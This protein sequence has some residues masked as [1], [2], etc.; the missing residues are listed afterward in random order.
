M[1]EAGDEA[2]GRRCEQQGEPLEL[3]GRA[4]AAERDHL[5]P[6]GLRLGFGIER[7]AGADPG[8]LDRPGRDRIHGDA[9]GRELERR[10]AD[11]VDDRRL[12][13]DVAVADQ[14]LGLDPGDRRRRDDPPR[15]LALHDPRRAPDRVQD[16]AQVH[17]QHAPEDVRLDRVDRLAARD[18]E[19]GRSA[20]ARVGEHDVEPAFGLDDRVDG[21]LHRV[22][23]GHV[24]DLG[25]HVQPAAGQRRRGRSQQL[26]VHVGQRH[27][28][29]AVGK[30]LRERETEAAGRAGHERAHAAH[31][32]DLLLHWRHPASLMSLPGWPTR[33]RRP[34]RP[35][36]RAPA[37]ATGRPR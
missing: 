17:V 13:R 33:P 26:G 1:C 7:R 28:R 9:V 12:G 20:D 5:R 24:D 35:A 34:G 10:L 16:S 11:D 15:P 32:E 37:C 23:I 30:H 29:A 6:A 8:A 31:V 14:R 25:A 19:A 27:V 2:G 18:R 21:A 4:H 22:A 3:G 36:G